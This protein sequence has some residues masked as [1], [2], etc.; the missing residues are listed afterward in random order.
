M[1]RTVMIAAAA[2][3]LAGAPALA[4]DPIVEQALS[5]GTVGEQWDGYLG[6][7]SSPSAD[8]KAAVDAINIKR[9]AGYTQIAAAR[10]VTVDQFAQTTACQ[11]LRAV[12]PGQAYR[13]KDGGWRKRNGSEAITPDYC[14]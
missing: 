11:T 14:G 5:G 2:L 9:R 7:V 13:L 1:S 12:K 3:A 6:F 4:A 8:L 10:N